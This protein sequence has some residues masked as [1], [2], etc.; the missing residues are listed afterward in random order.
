MEFVDLYAILGVSPD[1]TTHELRQAYRLA[2]RR[3][4]PDVNH[5]SGATIAFKD[6]NQAYEQ[7]T[8]PG[9][10][11]EYDRLREDRSAVM[12]GILLETLYSRHYVKLL[13]EPQ[14]LYV[15]VKIQPLCIRC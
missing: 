8:S 10:R 5:T 7:L 14:L 2:A 4:H 15:L 3:F 9:Q 13:P 6:I 1:A 12:P 11:A